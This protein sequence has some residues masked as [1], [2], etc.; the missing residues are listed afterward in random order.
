MKKL[1]IYAY[2][3]TIL[4][5]NLDDG[6]F[7]YEPTEKYAREWLGGSGTAQWILYNEIKPWV[8]PYDPAN[9]L[10]FSVGPLTGTLAP[11]SSR[12]SADS[13]SPVTMG[14]GTSNADSFFGQELKFAG[15]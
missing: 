4:R 5:I 8:S 7:I 11:G 1:D 12:M 15:L 2:A 6:S 13:K 14:V 10:I 9:R 3:G